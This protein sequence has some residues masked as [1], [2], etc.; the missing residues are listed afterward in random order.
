MGREDLSN[1]PSPGRPIDI[2]I[3][4]FIIRQLDFDPFSTARMIA[5]K[6]GVAVNTIITHLKKS[7]NM[8]YVHLQW[9]PHEL[10]WDQKYKRMEYSKSMLAILRRAKKNNYHFILTGDEAWF[11]YHY[12]PTHMWVYN[13]DERDQIVNKTN[14]CR[15]TMITIFFNIDGLQ[16]LDVKP[17]GVKINADYFIEN[18]I[19]PLESL[20]VTEKAQYQKQAMYLHFDNSPVHTSQKVNNYLDQTSFTLMPHPAYSP[21]LAPSDFGIFGTMKQ[22]FVGQD[23]ETEE[24]LIQAIYNFFDNL[25]K[26]FF[27]KIFSEWERRLNQ[28][29]HANGDYFC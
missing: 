6:S 18:I 22:S 17:K 20:E 10:N 15:K 13:T 14:F 5:R 25:P 24:Q 8:K 21:D 11:E 19:C 27:P 3:D 2:S 28:C 23:F 12:S 9:I 1:E 29:I 4:Q 7:L 16:L 26:D